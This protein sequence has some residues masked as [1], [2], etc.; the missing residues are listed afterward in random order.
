MCMCKLPQ[1][2]HVHPP[3]SHPAGGLSQKHILPLPGKVLGT[4]SCC[5]H[6][7]PISTN[8]SNLFMDEI[9]VKALSSYLHPSCLLL[10]FV[11]DTFSSYRQKTATNYSSISTHRTNIFSSPEKTQMRKVPYLSWTLVCPAPDNTLTNTVYWKLVQTD[12][13]LH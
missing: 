8:I 1:D 3:N 7:S 13:Y 10:R 11:D 6:G 12:Q 2:F 4:G 9:K 5:S